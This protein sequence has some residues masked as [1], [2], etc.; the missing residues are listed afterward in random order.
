MI[1]WKNSSEWLKSYFLFQPSIQS[2]SLHNTAH[3][4]EYVQ[5][6]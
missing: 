4:S 5:A 1:P 6:L 2:T 3:V